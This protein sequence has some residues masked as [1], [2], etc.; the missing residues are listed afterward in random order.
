MP[1]KLN[2][3]TA[4]LDMVMGPGSG[5]ATV[6]VAV[7]DNTAPGT[8]PVLPTGA[9][10]ITING[11]AVDAHLIPVETHSRAANEFNVE[12]QVASTNV[13][14]PGSKAKAGIA[15]FDST[16]FSV[17][18]HGYVTLIGGGASV[19]EFTTDIPGPVFP[20]VG[21]AVGVTGTSVFSDGTVANTLK[22]NIQATANTIL[23]G[24]GPLLTMSELGP[25]TNGQLIIGSTGLAPVAGSLT[26]TNGSVTITG[27]AGTIDLAVAA[28][29]DAILTLTGD[30]GGAL[31]PT[32]GNMYILG[33]PG[34][35]VTGTGSTLT[36]NSVVYY[37][38]TDSNYSGKR[39][40]IVYD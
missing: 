11:A 5:T 17:T 37:G 10:Q 21:G 1:L 9:G 26:S 29:N 28:S 32:S 4:C 33:G 20:S 18:E 34:V 38:P 2:P 16:D 35:T 23:Y 30:S 19:D 12:V 25:L 36:V 39:Q 3:A 8:N 13:G 15:Q 31:S 40:R 6:K 7:D 27:G 14:V 22:L 24:A